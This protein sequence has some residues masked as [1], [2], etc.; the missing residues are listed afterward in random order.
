MSESCDP[1]GTI[2]KRAS[3]SDDAVEIVEFDP[4]AARDREINAHND[5]LADRR[6]ETY[7]SERVEPMDG[8]AQEV[9]SR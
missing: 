5:V 6:P 1:T 2:L 8:V 7:V 3:Q 9:A 4:H